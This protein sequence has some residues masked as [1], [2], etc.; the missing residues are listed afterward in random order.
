[1]IAP[2]AHPTN[3]SIDLRHVGEIPDRKARRMLFW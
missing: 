2:L 3:G 1:M